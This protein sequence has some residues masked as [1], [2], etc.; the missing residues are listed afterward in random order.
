MPLVSGFGN[1]FPFGFETAEI[2][3]CGPSKRFAVV[4]GVP[5]GGHQF[6]KLT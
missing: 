1:N 3:V 2:P 6:I 5:Y 4:T